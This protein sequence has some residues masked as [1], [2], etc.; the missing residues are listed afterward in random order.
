MIK[1]P[2]L[3]PH[4]FESVA[5]ARQ[6]LDKA[7]S[8]IARMERDLSGIPTA[9]RRI[10]RE[11]LAYLEAR[12]DASKEYQN[13]VLMKA[14]VRGFLADLEHP[15]QMEPTGTERGL[16]LVCI[17]AAL[18]MGLDALPAEHT[19]YDTWRMDVVDLF[20]GVPV[21]IFW[22]IDDMD[23]TGEMYCRPPVYD[24]ASI[25]RPA[26]EWLYKLRRVRND[27]HCKLFE[28]LGAN[29]D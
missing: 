6:R 11:A 14:R 18:M 15:N 25:C 16:A 28:A 8:T 27:P 9:S 19:L 2:R 22:K 17:E 4:T 1:T 21:S 10:Q 23:S 5:D 24:D 3:E 13:Y 20:R 26:S 7:V 12:Q 29:N